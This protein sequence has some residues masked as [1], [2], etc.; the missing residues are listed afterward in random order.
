FRLLSA[1]RFV[2][3]ADEGHLRLV[4]VPGEPGVLA[5]AGQEVNRRGVIA[6]RGGVNAVGLLLPGRD[7]EDQ[8]FGVFAEAVI[9]S[10]GEGSLGAA[11]QISQHQV[12]A[13]LLAR[14]ASPSAGGSGAPSALLKIFIVVFILLLLRLR[15]SRFVVGF[16]GFGLRFQLISYPAR[17]VF[18]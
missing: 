5:F 17:G 16:P 9:Q 3:V 18:R 13:I 1:R 11:R 12:R 6:R 8:R 10:V 4:F 2:A 15:F 7:G 14:A